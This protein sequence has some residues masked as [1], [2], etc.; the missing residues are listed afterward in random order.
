MVVDLPL[1]PVMATKGASG[2]LAAALAGEELDV[3]DD[4]NPRRVGKV[5]GPVRLG[6][7][8]RHAGREHEQLEASPVGAGEIDE[9]N[10]RSGSA[11][12]GV[13]AIVPGG[14]IGAAGNQRPRG[15]QSRAAEAE[16]GDARAAHGLD[17]RHR[18]L[19]FSEARPTMASTKA[20]IQNRM[21]TCD[22][23]Q[24]SCSK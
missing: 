22:S 13:G 8:Q 10:P 18:H 4:R 9:R 21:T 6:M 14:D 20:M 12:A 3:A 24:P 23:D 1:V 2:A 19:S 17:R 5:D 16:E 15:R 7:G 11:F